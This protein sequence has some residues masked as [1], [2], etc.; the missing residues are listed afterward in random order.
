MKTPTRILSLLCIFLINN[1]V[2][3]G[4]LRHAGASTILR[5]LPRD[6]ILLCNW[7]PQFWWT[8]VQSA[9]SHSNSMAG[10]NQACLHVRA[11]LFAIEAG[12]RMRESVTCRQEKRR[13]ITPSYMKEIPYI[14]LMKWTFPLQRNGIVLWV[15]RDLQQVFCRHWRLGQNVDKGVTLLQERSS[16]RDFRTN[17]THVPLLSHVSLNRH[18]QTATEMYPGASA[19]STFGIAD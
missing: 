1:Y 12:V 10:L 8:S 9:D 17:G 2:E 4:C 16:P 5:F 11:L 19:N 13:W 3:V 6:Q 15:N 7:P 18:Q 14:L